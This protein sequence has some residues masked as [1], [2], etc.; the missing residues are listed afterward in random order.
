MLKSL[1]SLLSFLSV[2]LLNWASFVT[3]PTPEFYV[4]YNGDEP[5]PAEKVMKLSDAY[6]DKSK[7]PMLE[8]TVKVININL[9][10]NHQGL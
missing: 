6:L 10:E 7:A 4:F 5:C 2:S 8:L 3:I 1:A 9:P